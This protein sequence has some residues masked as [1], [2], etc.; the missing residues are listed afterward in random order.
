MAWDEPDVYHQPEKF[1]LTVVAEVDAGASYEFDMTVVW[2]HEDG[3]LFWATDSGCSCP[4]PFEAYTSL[5]DLSVLDATDYRILQSHVLGQ[6]DVTYDPLPLEDA[7]EFLYKVR[8]VM[9]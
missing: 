9:R 2:K 8:G 6:V 4:S 3:R 7:V 5:D 1:G